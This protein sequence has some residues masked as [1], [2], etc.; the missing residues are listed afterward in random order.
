[1]KKIS[2]VRKQA[3]VSQDQPTMTVGLD[4]G[5]R[6]SHYCL[7]NR[8][9]E[10]IEEGRMQSTEA[11]LQRHFE[12]EPRLRIERSGYYRTGIRLP[13]G[14]TADAVESVTARCH[15]H[16][17]DASGGTSRFRRATTRYTSITGSPSFQ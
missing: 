4:L 16:P 13:K 3:E 8:E 17:A 9:G 14:F 12:G 6:Y 7:L 2:K 1:M 10:V 5:D 11:A 15:P